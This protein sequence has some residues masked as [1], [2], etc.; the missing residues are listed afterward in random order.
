M[1]GTINKSS[2]RLKKNNKGSQSDDKPSGKANGAL[3]INY[4]AQKRSGPKTAAKYSVSKCGGFLPQAV[5]II[6][7]RNKDGSENFS[8]VTSVSYVFGPPESLVLSLYGSSRTKDNLMR[9][10]VFTVNLCTSS[11]G[12]MADYAGAVSGTS[13]EK[14]D[15]IFECT[16][17]LKVDAPV[18]AESPYTME[19]HVSYIWPIGDTHIV[20]AEIVNHL[21]DRKLGRP[22][23]ETDEAYFAWL[24]QSDLKEINPLLYA[25][26]YYQTGEKLG[27]LGELAKDLLSGG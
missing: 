1:P 19:C 20:V 16:P 17:G 13:Q 10:D 26:K 11:M 2:E 24:D 27:G 15:S 12:R 14:D 8:T 21:V 3:K 7:T 25:W 4:A 22:V 18:L 5:F 9:E 23:D 6:G